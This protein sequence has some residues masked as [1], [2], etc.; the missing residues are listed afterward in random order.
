SDPPASPRRRADPRRP[1]S[2]PARARARRR[3]PRRRPRRRAAPRP[4]WRRGLPRPAAR[5]RSRARR[6][7]R[8]RGARTNRSK[9]RALARAALHLAAQALASLARLALLLEARLLVEATTLDLLQDALLGHL[10]LEDL[11]RLLEAVAN[12]DLDGLSERVLGH[13]GTVGTRSGTRDQAGLL[14]GVVLVEQRDGQAVELG[15]RA[16]GHDLVD[17][18]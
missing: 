8:G 11:H 5:P 15:V 16:L 3:E 10:L 12:L 7:W 4:G 2:S 6:P 18:L 17:D 13:G 14:L 9:T 1:G